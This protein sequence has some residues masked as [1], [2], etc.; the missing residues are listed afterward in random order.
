MKETWRAGGRRAGI[1][2]GGVG[3]VGTAG[4]LGEESTKVMVAVEA[5]AEETASLT[6]LRLSSSRDMM[7]RGGADAGTAGPTAGTSHVTHTANML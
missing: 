2:V 4:R 3:G 1:W 6:V 5:E 7:W